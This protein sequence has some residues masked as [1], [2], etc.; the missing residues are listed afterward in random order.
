[1]FKIVLH[2]RSESHLLYSLFSFAC[3]RE[4]SAIYAIDNVDHRKSG[5]KSQSTA[6][7]TLR[8][9]HPFTSS[10]STTRHVPAPSFYRTMSS[11]V[12]PPGVTLVLNVRCVPSEPSPIQPTCALGESMNLTGKTDQRSYQMA[13]IRDLRSISKRGRVFDH[14]GCKWYSWGC[15]MV[16]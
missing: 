10:S 2:V 5:S 13:E 14:T 15:S 3:P 8:V 7:P 1:M 9:V 6:S 4:Y 11:I 12:T 16:H